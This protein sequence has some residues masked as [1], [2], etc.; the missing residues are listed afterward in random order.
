MLNNLLAS[1]LFS[2]RNSGTYFWASDDTGDALMARF[3]VRIPGQEPEVKVRAESPSSSIVVA[4]ELESSRTERGERSD[5][6][7]AMINVV[8]LFL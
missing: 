7:R 4:Q 3:S 8:Y 1:V 6:V 2:N 5:E